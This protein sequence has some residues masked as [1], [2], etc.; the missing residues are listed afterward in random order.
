LHCLHCATHEHV[1]LCVIGNSIAV[2]IAANQLTSHQAL[3]QQGARLDPGQN[4]DGEL[5]C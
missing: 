3:R 2:C 1:V 5:K 4:E